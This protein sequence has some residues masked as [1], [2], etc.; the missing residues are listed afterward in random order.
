MTS[1]S[2]SSRPGLVPALWFG[3]VALILLGLSLAFRFDW[4]V[5]AALVGVPVLIGLAIT[6]MSRRSSNITERDYEIS[7][8]GART[9]G[10]LE[11]NVPLEHAAEVTRRA[12]QALRRF[13][14]DHL[15]DTGGRVRA[16]W[17]LKTWGESI[18][19]TFRSIDAMRTEITA[20]CSPVLNTTVLDYGQG[21][22]DVER[23]FREIE[24]QCRDR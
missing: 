17:N 21:A 14:I 7:S 5:V 1:S 6:L 8:Q 13:E 4:S 20:E 11:A 2:S 10:R 18:D 12:I 16:S 23:I 24:N 3:A 15:S 22:E 9:T 19:L